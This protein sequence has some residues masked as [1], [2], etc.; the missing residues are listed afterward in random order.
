VDSHRGLTVR[1]D[2]VARHKTVADD[3]RDRPVRRRSLL[4]AL[5]SGLAGCATSDAGDRT[6]S[7][8]A[9]TRPTT[10]ATEQSCTPVRTG[11]DVPPVARPTGPD[12]S[13]AVAYR[14]ERAYQDWL[15]VDPATL[16]EVPGDAGPYDYRLVETL[17]ETDSDDGT[18]SVTVTALVGYT[19][20]TTGANGTVSE[21]SYD[22]PVGV[23]VYEVSPAGVTRQSGVG[24][25]TGRVVCW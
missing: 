23:A 12:E 11:F 4:C 16:S 5:L 8:A 24:D 7:P 22:Q 3:E 1:P 6:A 19:V 21:T 10:D 17:A 14:L 20:T 15:G 2:G 9:T 13:V 25:L 18:V